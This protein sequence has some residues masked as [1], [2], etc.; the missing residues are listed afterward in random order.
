MTVQFA[1]AKL[2]G[3][4]DL[5]TKTLRGFV[6][7]YHGQ[8]LEVLEK[9]SPSKQKNDFRSRFT[10]VPAHW[11][12]ALRQMRSAQAW[13]LAMMI[14]DESFRLKQFKRGKEVTLSG[15]VTNNMSRTTK[16]R[17]AEKLEQ[18]GLIKILERG[19]RKALR[20]IPL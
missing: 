6:I 19:N 18:H 12:S 3:K 10:L 17:V 5:R 7:D 4:S 2:P 8:L 9:D 15:K 14:L 1:S 20:I 16:I 13:D 11:R